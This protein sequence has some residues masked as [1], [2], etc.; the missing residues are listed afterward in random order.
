M[1]QRFAGEHT[2]L[3]NLCDYDDQVS[4]LLIILTKLLNS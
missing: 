1:H 3:R 2:A 4:R